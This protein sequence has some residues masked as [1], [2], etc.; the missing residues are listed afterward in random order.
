MHEPADYL[1]A[2]RVAYDLP[3]DAR[4]PG[5][6][7]RWWQPQ[8]RGQDLDHWALAHVELVM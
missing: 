5:V 4:R 3:G 8:H 6:Q 7:L 2:R 1:R